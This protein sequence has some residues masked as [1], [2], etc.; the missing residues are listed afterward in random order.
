MS[1]LG[2]SDRALV[3]PDKRTF[4]DTAGISQKPTGDIP[5]RKKFLRM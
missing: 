1:E 2:R 3:F 5:A 4:S